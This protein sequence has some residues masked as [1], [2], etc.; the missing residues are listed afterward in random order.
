[1]KLHRLVLEWGGTAVTGRAVTVLHY[2]G[3]E[4]AAPP[5]AAVKTVFSDH[6][7]LFPSGTTIDVPTIGDSIEDTTG[8]LD[9][10]WSTTG[11]GTVTGTTV[12]TTVLGVGACLGWSTGGIV[13]GTK[14]PRKLRGRTFLVPLAANVWEANGTFSSSVLAQLQDFADDLIATGGLAVWHRPQNVAGTDGNSYAVLTAKVRDKP[15]ML[16][17]RRD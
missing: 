3:T 17:T 10:V 1:M 4:D 7:A 12:G 2:D 9:G 6:A 8:D 11:G 15:A 13:P 5:V 16:T 14:G